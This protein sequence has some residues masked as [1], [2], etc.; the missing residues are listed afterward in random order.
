V[1]C[2]N[3]LAFYVNGSTLNFNFLMPRIGDNFVTMFITI[4]N[5]TAS[6]SINGQGPRTQSHSQA[7]RAMRNA[8]NNR[9]FNKAVR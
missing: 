9:F 1:P 8:L 4:D 5:K 6:S 3:D 7:C 2:P